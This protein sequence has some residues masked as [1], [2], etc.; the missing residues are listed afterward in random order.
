MQYVLKLTLVMLISFGCQPKVEKNAVLTQ[1]IEETNTGKILFIVSNQKT[2]GTSSIKASNHFGE[3]VYAYD[4]LVEAGYEIDFLSPKGGSVPF[5]YLNKSNPIQNKYL[6]DA[7]LLSKLK[8]T[9]TPNQIDVASY[10]VVYYVGGGAAMY[11]VPENSEIQKIA[12][13]VYEK[14]NGIVSAICHG[15]AGIVN[16]KTS[17]GEYIYKG[18]NVNGYPDKF[19]RMNAA[20]YKEFPFS[21]EQ[22]LKKNGGNFTYSQKNG[23]QYYQVDGRLITG[24]DPSSAK[25]V[26]QKIIESLNNR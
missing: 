9:L 13:D 10:S 15:V 12:M 21:I 7:K 25:I 19:E 2:Y 17:N 24:Q 4:V 11:G 23:A 14:N 22:K 1:K 5:G 8:N 18:K 6:K 16:L 3:I 20:Y 26:A